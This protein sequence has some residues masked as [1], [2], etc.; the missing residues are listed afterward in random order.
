EMLGGLRAVGGPEGTPCVVTH[1][2]TRK[3]GALLAYLAYFPGR[4]HPRELLAE[5]LWPDEDSEA[6]R[7]RLRA[8][9]AALRRILEPPEISPGS[10][11]IA[12][13]VT[14]QLD[15]Q[16]VVT[17]VS[18]FEAAL[19]HAARATTPADRVAILTG[20]TGLYRG[21]LLAGYYEEWIPPERQRLADACLGALARLADDLAAVGDVA[22]AIGLARQAVAID[23]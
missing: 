2:E 8:A 23:P 14:A 17:D 9:F 20:A 5:L 3:T 4:A 19:Q 1:F 10:V 18:E 22:S 16:A 15:R 6:T 7:V 11:L 21:D 13:R 12:D